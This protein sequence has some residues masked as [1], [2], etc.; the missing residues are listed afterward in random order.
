MYAGVTEEKGGRDCVGVGSS[1]DLESEVSELDGLRKR[2]ERLERA[3]RL[4]ERE[5]RKQE[6]RKEG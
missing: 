3:A 5:V 2:R 4:L 6:G 1:L